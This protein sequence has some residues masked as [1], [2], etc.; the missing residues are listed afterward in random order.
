MPKDFIDFDFDRLPSGFR[1]IRS[2]SEDWGIPLIPVSSNV[3]QFYERWRF[4]DTHT[5]RNASVAHLLAGGI[6]RFFYGSAYPWCDQKASP[7]SDIAV[8]DSMLLPLLST[9]GIT[10]QSGDPELSR[11][12]KTLG[13]VDFEAANQYLQV[14]AVGWE[15]NCSACWKCRRTLLTLDV[16]DALDR[17]SSVFDVE[18]YLR[19]RSSWAATELMSADPFMVDIVRVAK[20]RGVCL[21]RFLEC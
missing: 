12:E 6:D 20:A 13:L 19:D 9:R 5:I 7:T 18:R 4:E 8:A 10:L 3:G 14:C 15:G 16:F 21:K 17:F 2:L 1:N 11:A